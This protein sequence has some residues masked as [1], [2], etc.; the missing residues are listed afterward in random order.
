MAP[1]TVFTE[2]RV[3]QQHIGEFKTNEQRRF[4]AALHTWPRLA[5]RPPRATTLHSLYRL[6]D[7]VLRSH[8]S[9]EHGTW[10]PT[11]LQVNYIGAARRLLPLAKRSAKL[12][13]QTS[14]AHVNNEHNPQ[15]SQAKWT[16]LSI[17]F[18]PL[19]RSYPPPSPC[20]LLGL[21]L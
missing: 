5:P 12:G 3:Y 14:R 16:A 1:L 21:T 6:I 10:Q 4:A 2:K 8:T 20:P 11:Y 7:P 15:L 18:S 17:P 9:D 19:Y 13:S